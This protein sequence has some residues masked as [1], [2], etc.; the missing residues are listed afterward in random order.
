MAA[1]KKPKTPPIGYYTGTQAAE[2]LKLPLATFY[3]RLK[4]EKI[5]IE[6]FVPTGYTEGFYNKKAVDDLAQERELAAILHSA[7]P[8]TFDRARTEDDLRGIVDLCIAIYGQTGTPSY[9][10]RRE[11]WEKNP[12]VYYIVKQEGIVVGYISLIWFDEEA[13]STL[14]GPTPK[15]TR[16]SSAGTGVYSVTGPD[17]VLPFVEGQPIDSLFISLGVRPG[18]SNEEQRDYAIKLLRGTQDVLVNFVERGMPIRKLYATSERAD[19]IR[20]AKRLGMKK[21]EY[22][23]DHLLRYGLD[24]ETA[25]SLLLKPYKDALEAITTRQ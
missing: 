21:T 19:G 8:I 23:G 24:L 18:M 14:M 22:P 15:Q 9:D 11:I 4:A 2:R 1:R 12:E 6:K 20:M 13:L 17:H 5:K 3:H 16:I 25:D 10:A 7:A